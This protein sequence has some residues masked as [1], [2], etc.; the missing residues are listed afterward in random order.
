MAKLIVHQE[1]LTH[2]AYFSKPVLHLWADGKRIVQGLY[3]AFNQFG[4]TLSDMRVEGINPGEQMISVTLGLGGIHRF[5]F[6]HVETTLFQIS[7]DDYRR[8][9]FILDASLAWIRESDSQFRVSSHHFTH[10]VHAALEEESIETFLNRIGPA[11]PKSGGGVSKGSGVIFRWESTEKHWQTR[12]VLDE[13][14]SVPKG[15]FVMFS[16]ISNV[17]GLNFA[18]TAQE[19]RDCYYS[20]LKELGIEVDI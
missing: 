4:M 18:Q 12:L 3:G 17:D 19:A 1:Q 9:P 5:K 16:L 14:I 11:A 10:T 20:I 13:S 2:T 8:L 15:L 7:E 6:D